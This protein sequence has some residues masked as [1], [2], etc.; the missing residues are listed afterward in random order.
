MALELQAEDRRARFVLY[1]QVDPV[2]EMSSAP[3]CDNTYLLD[4]VAGPDEEMS[5]APTCDNTYLL[6]DVA[7]DEPYFFEEDLGY[8]RWWT[9]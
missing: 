1:D 6:D 9:E 3:T 4:G 2:E 5:W 8:E 7:G